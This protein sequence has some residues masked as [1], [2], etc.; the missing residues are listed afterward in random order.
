MP[1][2]NQS[3]RTKRGRKPRDA[4]SY[5]P[6]PLIQAVTLVNMNYVD[7]QTISETVAGSGAF[8]TYR[9]SDLFDPN[10]TGVGTQ[11]VGFDQLSTLYTRFRVL[12]VAVTVEAN[13]NATTTTLSAVFPSS[14]STL[15]AS[16]FSWPLQ[17]MARSALLN[18][19][20]GGNNTCRFHFK[21]DPAKVLGLTKNQYM[22]DMDY[23]CTPT[24]SPVRS[25][26]IHLTC[27]GRGGVLTS[28]VSLIRM[29]YLVECSEPYLNTIS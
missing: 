29:Q 8:Y 23:T 15:P 24:A 4:L 28:T 26:F 17:P 6:K 1:K 13:N 19:P 12:S 2:R 27:S 22:S 7:I 25:V 3:Q 18:L 10:F 5:I 16:P 9:I 21:L 11:P 14:Q 20:A